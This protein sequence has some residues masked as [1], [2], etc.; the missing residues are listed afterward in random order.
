M[1]MLSK[2]TNRFFRLLLFVLLI[3]PLL[4]CGKRGELVAPG[5]EEVPY[6]RTYPKADMPI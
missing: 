5:K 6:P 2:N 4:G 1:K 3:L